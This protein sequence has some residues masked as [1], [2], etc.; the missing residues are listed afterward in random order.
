VYHV[1]LTQLNAG[2]VQ[3]DADSEALKELVAGTAT[4]LK[5]FSCILVYGK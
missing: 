5:R 1:N 3:I 2:F 4:P